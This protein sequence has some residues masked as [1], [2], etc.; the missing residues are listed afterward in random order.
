MV[1]LIPPQTVLTPSGSANDLQA[2]GLDALGLTAPN[3]EPVWAANAPGT[4]S[5]AALSLQVTG[6]RAPFRAI[7]EFVTAPTDFSGPDGKS[8][9]GPAAV[10]RLHP[11]AA[12]RLS[13]LVANRLGQTPP[14]HPVPVAMVVHG[15]ALPNPV[16]VPE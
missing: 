9:T 6:L 3:I 16:P 4:Y 7:R 13:L 1:A 5:Q 11:E 14:I 2:H 15:V 8:M 10:L 12:R